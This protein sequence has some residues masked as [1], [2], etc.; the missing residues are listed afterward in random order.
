L[1]TKDTKNA[2]NEK[3]PVP[4]TI[5]IGGATSNVGIIAVH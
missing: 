3:T 1:T 5:A 2:K 4:L